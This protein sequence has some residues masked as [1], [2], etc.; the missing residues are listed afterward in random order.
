VHKNEKEPVSS[1]GYCKK[2]LKMPDL[3]HH[4]SYV[5]FTKANYTEWTT[6]SFLDPFM[7]SQRQNPRISQELFLSSVAIA[8]AS[9][10]FRTDET[11]YISIPH[12][13]HH[14]A[15]QFSVTNSKQTN[16]PSA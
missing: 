9:S 11:M 10:S 5:F 8:V 16:F 1:W 4:L 2:E 7:Q 14:L 13:R 15:S 3:S 6:V 12:I